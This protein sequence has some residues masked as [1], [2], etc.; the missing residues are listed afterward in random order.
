MDGQGLKVDGGQMEGAVVT[1]G[2]APS[3]L[4]FAVLGPLQV[5]RAG[6][7]VTPSPPRQRALLAVLLIHAGEPVNL[8]RLIEEIWEEQPPPGAVNLIRGYVSKL[9]GCLGDRE[10]AVLRTIGTGYLLRVP[11]GGLDARDFTRLLSDSRQPST[12]PERRAQLLTQAEQLWRGR[13]YSG[14]P[15]LRSVQAESVR[16][17]EDRLSG[18]EEG[19]ELR[20]G[21]G[22]HAMVVGTLGKLAATHPL[23]ERLR[24]QLIVALSRCG[25]Q[26]DALEVYREF[27]QQVHE[28]LGVEP[29]RALRELQ[30]AVL[31]QDPSLDPPSPPQ[32]PPVVSPSLD[33]TRTRRPTNLSIS[34]RSRSRTALVTTPTTAPLTVGSYL[35]AKDDVRQW[36]DTASV[37]PWDLP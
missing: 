32:H 26:A 36:G 9:R 2:A 27:R 6:S 22:E 25:R 24:H 1:D 35:G 5:L 23:R 15:S 3:A 28:E 19:I 31:R 20:L 12:S 10:G 8:D 13:P 4:R 16:L 29:S 37:P 18:L 21:A 7:D 14:V 33:L 11:P 17:E 34:R 30:A